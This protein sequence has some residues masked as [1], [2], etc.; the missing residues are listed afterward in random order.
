M[1]RI[2]TFSERIKEY[3]VANNLTL[4]EL[5]QKVNLPAQTINRYELAQRIPK[6]DTAL[7]IADI[8]CVN[9][10]WLQGYDVDIERPIPVSEGG[11]SEDARVVALAYEKATSKDQQTVH[12]VLSDYL[13][14]A[15]TPRELAARTSG[16]P[17]K[18]DP[19]TFI[20]EGED[21]DIP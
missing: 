20:I 4:A 6:I 17:I 2:A 10:L 14:D 13:Q 5:A 16:E 18:D 15:A 3:R 7:E 9:P 8:L 11:L 21:P 12:F 1:I 19:S